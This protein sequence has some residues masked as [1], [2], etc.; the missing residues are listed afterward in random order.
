[1]I[2]I[3][4]YGLIEAFGIE[5]SGDRVTA[6]SFE[7]PAEP[8][9]GFSHTWDNG[10]VEYD[11]S[12]PVTFKPRQ[13]VIKGHLIV[14]TLDEYLITKEAVNAI[15]LGPYVTLEKTDIGFKANAKISGIPT[16]NRLTDLNGKI[17]VSVAFNFNEVLQPAPF[18]D[19]GVLSLTYLTD[20]TG[21]IYTTQE[22]KLITIS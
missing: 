15:I 3:N 22:N 17:Y 21:N 9:E 19:D 2:K 16:W 1:M 13:F 10:M 4:G 20:S 6:D 7:K 12:S 11:L 14:D 18:I 8:V 5:T